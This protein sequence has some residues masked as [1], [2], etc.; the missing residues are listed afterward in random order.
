MQEAG[1]PVTYGYISDI[2]EKKSG[3]TGCTTTSSGPT[4]PG[5]PCTAQTA[6]A[7][8]LAFKQFLDRLAQ[9]G[10]TPANTEFVIGAEENDHFAGAN[11]GRALAPSCSGTTCSYAAGQIG[12]LQ[13]NL[14]DMLKTQTADT[15][16]F[17][18]EPQ[19]AAM[20]VHG[21]ATTPQPTADDPA[22]RQLERDTATLTA[23]NPYSGVAGEKV[24]QYQAGAAEQRILHLQTGDPLRTPTYT[25]F[26]KP[27]YFFCQS[28]SLSSCPAGVTINGRFAWNHG[29]YAPDID[30]TWTAFAGPGVQA[31]GVDGRSP[32][33]A[34]ALSDPNGLGTVP[35]FSATGTWAD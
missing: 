14:P 7:Y 4:G 16:A 17:D 25:I 35:P 9:D 22:V 3:Q 6:T 20:Y 23:D 26:P 34:P 30:I 33:Q 8:D 32:E 21:T 19:G 1:I 27:D 28:A 12:E 31:L 13:A 18:V 15:T 24:V 5:D 11:A 2:H 10:I 29:Y